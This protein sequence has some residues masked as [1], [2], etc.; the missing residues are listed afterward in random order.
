MTVKRESLLSILKSRPIILDGATGTELIARGLSSGEPPEGWN[1]LYPERVQDV[2]RS[3]YASGSDVVVSN[4]FGANRIKLSTY[5][6]A[7]RVE[8]INKK[9]CEILRNACTKDAF[10]AGNIGPTG[11]FLKP[12]GEFEPSEFSE[13][14]EEQALALRDGGADLIYIETMYDLKEA[15]IALEAAKK[16]GLPVFVTMTFSKKK[17]GFFTIMGDTPEISLKKL[18]DEGADAVGANCSL[19]C[20]EMLDLMEGMKNF[21]EIPF[22]AKPNAGQPKVND[23]KVYYDANPEDFAR[24]IEKMISMGVRLVGGCCGTSPL[25]I[26]KIAEIVKLNYKY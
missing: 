11:K 25:F 26:K 15:L 24:D 20:Y 2:H 5:G 22:I 17:K 18:Y 1:I 8:E 16:T 9:A 12:V 13:V 14:Y 7:E 21:S 6:Y 10:V 3:Y 19:E 4:S 23:G